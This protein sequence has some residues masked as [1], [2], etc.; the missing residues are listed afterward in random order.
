MTPILRTAF[1]ATGSRP[2][3][4]FDVGN[5]FEAIINWLGANL[6]PFFDGVTALIAWRTACCGPTG[7][8]W[9]SCW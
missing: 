9:W 6:E 2:K 1:A 4:G 3:W 7:R 5:F 8:C